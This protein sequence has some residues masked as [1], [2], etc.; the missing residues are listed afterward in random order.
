MSVCDTLVRI[1]WGFLT[2]GIVMGAL[3]ANEAW[4]AYWAWDPK[5]TWAAV[6]WIAY[7]L[8]MHS[9]PAIKKNSR[10]FAL[11][12]FCFILLQMCWWGVNYLPSAQEFSA[13]TY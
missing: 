3:W 13:H 7:L 1:G 12:L 2:L 4:G 11:L 6:T 10:A 8:Y 9:R 5:E